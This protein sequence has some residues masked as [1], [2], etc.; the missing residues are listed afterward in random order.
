MVDYRQ[1]SR[2][3]TSQ[4]GRWSQYSCAS[5]SSVLIRCSAQELLGIFAD[6][7]NTTDSPDLGP[8]P[9]AHFEEGDPIKFDTTQEQ[10]PVK[11]SES[12]DETQLKLSANLETRKKRRE[13]SHRRDVDFGNANV[14]ATMSTSYV[15]MA[16]PTSQPL[17]SGAKRKL[18]VHDDDDPPAKVKEPEK[19]DISLDGRNSDLRMSDN[20]ITTLLPGA[21]VKAVGER[22]SEAAL[23][24]NPG[25]DSKGKASVASATVTANS[26]K[27][28]GPSKCCRQLGFG[29][30]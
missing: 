30:F 1:L 17:K 11:T 5:Y 26:R 13:S 10:P 16:I 24:G 14:G 9:V 8:P 25:K 29:I 7:V 21:A 27:A 3:N 4:D 12:A 2:I 18:N 19:R 23:R 28:L 20:G 15:D 22:S 6:P